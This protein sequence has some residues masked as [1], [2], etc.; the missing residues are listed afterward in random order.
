MSVPLSAALLLPATA[1]SAAVPGEGHSTAAAV[2]KALKNIKVQLDD[3]DTKVNNVIFQIA[4]VTAPA[5]GVNP[6]ADAEIAKVLVTQMTYLKGRVVQA[7]KSM[8][9]LYKEASHF[10]TRSSRKQY[11]KALDRMG[12][13]L[14]KELGYVK[15]LIVEGN[16]I[17]A[18]DCGVFDAMSNL[19]VKIKSLIGTRV[20]AS[21]NVLRTY[22]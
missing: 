21:E 5:C 7:E 11:V 4:S 19:T 17:A 14:D 6:R 15:N 13:D 18:G 8:L 10:T 12:S 1:A 2:T 20:N 9:P 3:V 22:E 16:E